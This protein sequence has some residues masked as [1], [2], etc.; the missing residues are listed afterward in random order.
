MSMFDTW[1]PHCACAACLGVSDRV[2]DVH[3]TYQKIE[4]MVCHPSP[5]MIQH[6]QSVYRKSIGSQFWCLF[7]V[8][9]NMH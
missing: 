8:K 1:I 2:N 4:W 7:A 6:H 3:M 5:S 9:S